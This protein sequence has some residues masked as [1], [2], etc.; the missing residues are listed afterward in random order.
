M[1]DEY[2]IFTD[3]TPFGLSVVNC[4]VVGEERQ[5]LLPDDWQTW[6]EALY[7]NDYLDNELR[8]CIDNKK[9]YISV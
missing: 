1:K 2:L 3:I 7:I 9:T 6:E 8:V 5:I 4:E